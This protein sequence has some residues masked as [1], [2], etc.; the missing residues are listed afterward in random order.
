MTDPSAARDTGPAGGEERRRVVT[1]CL[2]VGFAVGLYGVAFG[3]ASVAAG[4]TPAQTS[5]SS[6]LT[7]TGGSQFAVAGVIAGGGTVATALSGGYLLGARNTLY[8]LRMSDLLQV[9]GWRRPLAALFT[10]DE[11]TAM[12]LGQRSPALSRLAFWWTG[13]AV[14]LLWN[15]ATL[16]GALG[17]SALGDPRRFG[18][19]AA[20]PAAF[21]ALLLPQLKPAG[22]TGPDVP[23]PGPDL[24]GTGVGVPGGDVPGAAAAGPG[25]LRWPRPVRRLVLVAA[26][27]ALIAAVLVPLT[28]A[29]V[30]V[31][32]AGA[33]LVLLVPRRGASGAPA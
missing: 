28:P 7:F 15:L 21:L 18:L 13:A 19:D 2:G 11:S 25:R 29:G 5:A 26:L 32:A 17:A 8:A 20:I 22:A 31:L 16:A 24:P 14:Y 3:A 12:A 23:D 30:P 9:S 6:L 10:I 1:A 4:F 27:A 33:A